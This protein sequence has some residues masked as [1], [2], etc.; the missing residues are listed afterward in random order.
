MSSRPGTRNQKEDPPSRRP[1]R[2][3]AYLGPLTRCELAETFEQATGVGSD[4]PGHAPAE[5]LGRQRHR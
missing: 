4:A 3:E 1:A 5:L 2:D